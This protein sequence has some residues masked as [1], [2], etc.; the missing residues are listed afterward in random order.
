MSPTFNIIQRFNNINWHCLLEYTKVL[1]YWDSL[2]NLFLSF[3]L[4]CQGHHFFLAVLFVLL[5]IYLFIYL[6]FRFYSLSWPTLLLFYIPYLLPAPCLHEDVPT[7]YHPPLQT[8]KLPEASIL[9]RVRCIFSDWTQT[10]QSS[11]VYVLGAS[12][13]LVY[14]AWL[15]AQCLSN[16]GIPG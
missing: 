4:I 8:S 5:F 14:A 13:Q 1:F 10:W 16:L 3:F 15:V 12:Y 7:T 2:Y 6:Y 9:L 11:A